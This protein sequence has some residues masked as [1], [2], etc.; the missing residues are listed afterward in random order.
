MSETT[1]ADLH[2]ELAA[3]IEA[4]SDAYYRDGT[5]PLSDAEYD[6]LLRQLGDL[7]EQYPALVS[8]D[9]PTQRVMGHA[10]TD[11]ASYDHLQRMESLDNAFSLEEVAG[12]Y[13]RVVRD[14]G[15]HP[16]LLCE[17]K[18]DGLAINLLYEDGR[19][20]RALTRGDGRTGEDVTPNVRT[21]EGVPHRLT[22]TAEHPVPKL[23]EVRGEVY[24]P[25]ARF[26][27]INAE[28]E[29]AGKPLYA[30]ARNTAAGSL[31]QKD[32]A[33]TAARRLA[34]VCHGVGARDGFEPVSQS[35]AYAV[36]ASWGLPISD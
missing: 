5:S 22:G 29:A 12:W 35:Q 19:L 21:I 32:P 30:N 7:E 34:M 31:R 4:A 8:A 14:A 26:E 23:I 25:T 11:F 24:L 9:S 10:Y 13:D 3:R 28:Q 2:A 36:L 27:E 15:T 6:A 17:V 1:P 20:T 16:E 33:I 18:F